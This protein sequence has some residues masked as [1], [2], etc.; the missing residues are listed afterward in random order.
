MLAGQPRTPDRPLPNVARLPT[1]LVITGFTLAV[2]RGL[3]LSSWLQN[4][5]IPALALWALSFVLA[6]VATALIAARGQIPDLWSM[7]VANAL[8]AAG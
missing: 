4:R 6:A 5:S 7:L 1:S 8:L 2:A 3:L